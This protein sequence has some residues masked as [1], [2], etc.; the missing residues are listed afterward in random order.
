MVLKTSMPQNPKSF[1]LANPGRFKTIQDLTQMRPDC[2][3]AIDD[4][5]MI[6]NELEQ[7]FQFLIL[8]S[9]KPKIV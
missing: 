5:L 2:G 6:K 4:S 8:L 7:P 1:I 3:A 9:F